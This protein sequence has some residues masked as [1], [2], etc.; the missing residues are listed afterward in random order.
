MAGGD[1]I[2]AKPEFRI[3]NPLE[4]VSATANN[5]ISHFLKIS[6]KLN[7]IALFHVTHSLGGIISEPVASGSIN[8]TVNYRIS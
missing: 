2:E 7:V 5:P 8:S 6:L 4:L 1:N 3:R